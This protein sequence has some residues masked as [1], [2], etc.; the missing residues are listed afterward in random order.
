MGEELLG[1]GVAI[2]GAIVF[3]SLTVYSLTRKNKD[4]S[5]NLF[6]IFTSCLGTSQ[7]L[8]F[9]EFIG[10]RD[11]ASILLRF[12]LT[13]LIL[14]AYHYVLFADYFREGINKKFIIAYLI[15]T[16]MIIIMV[17]TV[18][19]K[20]VISGPYGWAGVY[21][22]ISNFIYG[23]FGVVCIITGLTIFICIRRVVENERIKRKMDIFITGSLIGLIGAAVNIAVIQTVGR[24]F[25]ILETTLMLS[26][27][28]LAIGLTK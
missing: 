7:L 12:D 18:M 8:S 28:F 11:M 1:I 9:F 27:I 17:F 6:A 14:G 2:A 25:P 22:P 19:I 21:Y 3:Y 15:P 24:I 23:L 5:H 4:L 13:F 16:V 26:G 10:T 20:D